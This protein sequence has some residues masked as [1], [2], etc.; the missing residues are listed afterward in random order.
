MSSDPMLSDCCSQIELVTGAQLQF[1][2]LKGAKTIGLRKVYGRN[3]FAILV[4]RCLFMQPS[5]KLIY[6]F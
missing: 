5:S 3:L 4:R 1:S 6:Y 2:H